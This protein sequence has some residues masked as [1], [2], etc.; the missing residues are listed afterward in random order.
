MYDSNRCTDSKRCMIVND[1]T[2]KRCLLSCMIVNR[3]TIIVIVYIV[4][5]V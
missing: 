5:D 2:S 4:N 1:L 3:F